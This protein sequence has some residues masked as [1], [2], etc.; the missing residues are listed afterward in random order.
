MRDLPPSLLRHEG[1]AQA[2]ALHT[3]MLLILTQGF[4]FR[5]LHLEV[6]R[7]SQL[8]WLYRAGTEARVFGHNGAFERC[9]AETNKASGKGS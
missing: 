1:G 3:A 2:S 4:F 6:S 7:P 5:I 9:G 8:T